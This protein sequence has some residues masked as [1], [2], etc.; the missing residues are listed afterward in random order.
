MGVDD[1]IASGSASMRAS[2]SS[3]FCFREGT[4]ETSLRSLKRRSKKEGNLRGKVF[5]PG[6]SL[7]LPL[8]FGGSFVTTV[9]SSE[10]TASVKWLIES[11]KSETRRELQRSRRDGGYANL[12]NIAKVAFS[13]AKRSTRA[14]P[15]SSAAEYEKIKNFPSSR[16]GD[17]RKGIGPRGR[18]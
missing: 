2:S 9:E 15:F 8:R 4:W 3:V 13:P 14:V 17:E 6:L 16:R 7:P 18:G 11:A 12:C 5:L 1:V 10:E